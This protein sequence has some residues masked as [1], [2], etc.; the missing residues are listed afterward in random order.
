M[1]KLLAR[2]L[3]LCLLC[4]L[5][6]TGVAQADWVKQGSHWRYS[7]ADGK[8]YVNAWLKDGGNW[9]YFD[10]KGWMVTGWKQIGSDWYYF[11]SN[12][13][14][15]VNTVIDGHKIGADGKMEANQNQTLKIDRSELTMKPGDTDELVITYTASGTL[16]YHVDDKN[17]AQCAFG[18][19]YNSNKNIKLKV[20]AVGGGS[21]DIKITN[22]ANSEELI[23]KVSVTE[24]WSKV[25]VVNPKTMKDRNEPKNRMS[26][27]G[28]E[29]S[30]NNNAAY[31]MKV[32]YKMV[33]Y[34]NKRKT[35]WGQYVRYYDKN[36]A[37]LGKALL[38]TT[39]LALGKTYQVTLNVPMDTAKIVFAKSG[40]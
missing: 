20:T 32:T 4:S 17:V 13:A 22:S 24:P 31:R 3:V 38:Y 15:A 28:W 36:G 12:G 14:M 19:W 27:T 25:K 39:N 29:F 6:L 23:I 33:K 34:G 10:E 2:I 30:D 40:K 35:T 7:D 5:L 8:Y 11:Y 16:F 37:L 9:Y 18:D 21:T 1:K 26:V